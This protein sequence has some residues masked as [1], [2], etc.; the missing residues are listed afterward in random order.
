MTKKLITLSQHKDICQKLSS[1]KSKKQWL[2]IERM[3]HALKFEPGIR[4]LDALDAL[5]K[6]LNIFKSHFPHQFQIT[7]LL[8]A[9]G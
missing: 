7:K 6:E 5:L 9:I 2:H 3:N 4:V 1:I 8:R